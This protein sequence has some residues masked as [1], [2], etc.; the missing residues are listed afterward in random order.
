[1]G[2]GYIQLLAIGSESYFLNYNPNISFFKIYFRRHTNFYINNMEIT[3]NNIKTLNLIDTANKNTITINIPKNG[4]L[5]AKS[6]LNLTIDEY[7]FELFK[8]NEVLCSTLNIDLLNVYDNYYIKTNNYTIKDIANILII[9][10]NFFSTNN[11]ILSVVSS[12]VF[13][14]S[15]ILNYINTQETITL[16]TDAL[17]IFYNIDLNLLFYSFNDV[18]QSNILSNELFNYLIQSIL[19]NKLLYLQIDFL[20]NNI[21][22]KITYHNYQYYK[23]VIDLLI[24]KKF[25]D[26]INKIK[27]DIRYV[28]FSVSF[29]FELYNLL[30]ELFYINSEIFE[31]EIINNKYKS[32]KNVLNEK[33]YNKITSM[34]L[35]KNTDTYI[36]LSILNGDITSYSIITIMEKITFFGNLT[37][38]YYNDLLIQNSNSLLNIFNVNNNKLSLNLLIKIFVS[39]MCYDNNISI[40]NYLKII[41]ENNKITNLDIIKNI[42][43]YELSDKIITYFMDPNILIVNLKTF[44]VIL[45]T[46]NIYQNLQTNFYTR[47]FTNNHKSYYTT[48][49]NTFYS[50]YNLI[51]TTNTIINNNINDYDYMVSQL[52]FFNKFK[53]LSE[54]VALELN[55]LVKNYISNNNLFDINNQINNT[56]TMSTNNTENISINTIIQN[57]NIINDGIYNN[58]LFTLICQS[59]L[60][61]NNIMSF[62]YNYLYSS[63]G[64]LSNVFINSK[65]SQYIFP[66][67]SSIYISTN[68]EGEKCNNNYISNVLIY[69]LNKINYI[70][71]IQNSLYLLSEQYFDNYKISIDNNL[72]KYNMNKYLINSK[73]Y[74]LTSK[75]Y[76]DNDNYI[77]KI[78]MKYINTFLEQIKNIN[79]N[80][81]YP[82]DKKFNLNDKIMFDLFS[83]VDKNLFNDSFQNFTFYKENKCNTPLFETNIRNELI[84]QNFIFTINSPLYRIYFYFTFISKITID[85]YMNID[86]NLVILRNLTFCFLT[87]FLRI[88]NG[89]ILDENL[90]NI[91]DKFNLTKTN[92]IMYFIENNFMCYDN[93]NIFNNN[94]FNDLI[95]NKTSNKY[96]YLYNNFY[97]IKKKISNYN[98]NNI[99]FINNIP[100]FCNELKYN[101]DDLIMK[102]FFDTL[103]DNKN[104]FT[105]FNDIYILTQHFFNK[106]N[107]N[108]NVLMTI[109]NNFN[110]MMSYDYSQSNYDNYTTNNFLYNCYYTSYYIGI[111]FDN[112]NKNNIEIINNVVGLTTLYNDKY[113]FN[114]EYSLKEFNSKQNI[115]YIDYTNNINYPLKYFRIKLYDIFTEKFY[116]NNNYFKNYIEILSSYTN[117]NNDY[118]FLYLIDEYD[119]YNSISIIK[120]YLNVFNDVN[121]SSIT[122]NDNE[123]NIE[124]FT[125]YNFIVIIYYY[126]YFIYKCLSRD[127]NEFNTYNIN[128]IMSFQEF[129]INKYTVNIYDE[130]I[131][132][133]IIIYTKEKQNITFDFS[134]YYIYSIDN[135]VHDNIIFQSM[136]NYNIMKKNIF[137]NITDNNQEINDS[138]YNLNYSPINYYSSYFINNNNEKY[139]Y[140]NKNFNALYCKSI[141]TIIAK[142]NTIFYINDTNNEALLQNYNVSLTSVFNYYEQKKNYYDNSIYTL[143]NIYINL[144]K[145]TNSKIIN[146]QNDTYVS[147]IITC[148][149]YN[150]K[151][152]YFEKENNY[153]YTMYYL[154]YNKNINVINN[155][156]IS[157]D[158]DTTDLINSIDIYSLFSKYINLLISYSIIYE[159]SINRIIYILSTNYLIDNSYNKN[160]TINELKNKTLYDITKL[161]IDDGNNLKKEKIYLNNT[162][163]Y[164]NQSIF[165]IY[166]YENW[167]NNISF[168]QN[169]WVNYIISNI[170]VDYESSNSYHNLFSQ[171]IE[172]VKFFELNLFDFVLDDGIPVLEYFNDI[173]NYDELTNYIFNYLCLNE[174]YSPNLIFNNIIDL[175][176]TNDISSK[177]FIDTEHLKKKI[178]VFLFFTWII[179][180][181][182]QYLLVD[183]KEINRNIVIE[184]NLINNI[185]IKLSNVIDNGN[186]NEII[187]WSIYQ[188]FNMD[189]NMENKKFEITDYPEFIQKNLEILYI[190]K[191]TKFLC[192]PIK[193]FNTLA[194]K[195]VNMYK[196]IIGN[197]NIYTNNL[198]SNKIYNPTITNLI[199]DINVIF[200]NDINNNNKQQYD[201]T[202]YSL[203]LIDIKFKS[204]IYDLTNTT[205]NSSIN[206]SEFINKAKNNYNKTVINDFNLSY[207]LSC[208]L[209]NNY[210][211][212]Y[213]DLSKD[214]NFVINN[215]RRG[216]NNINELFEMF[217]GYITNYTLSLDLTSEK[218]PNTVYNFGIKLFNI[219]KL[220]E[221]VSNNN[222]NLS[223]IAPNDYDVL[224]VMINYK[225]AYNNFYTKYYSYEYNYNNF[226]NNYVVIYKKLYEYYLNL[227]NNTQSIKNIKKYN[228]NLYIWL[229]IDLINATISNTFYNITIQNPNNYIDVINQLIKLYF[230]YNYSFRLNTNIPNTLNLKIQKK[231]YDVPSLN[232]YKSIIE[233]I[234]SYYYYQLF[235]VEISKNDITSYNY[236]IIVFFD[237]LNIEQNLN[238]IYVKNYLNCIFKFIT[239][240]KFIH[241][242]LFSIYN[243]K[244]SVSNDTLNKIIISLIGY[245]IE[246]ENI[247]NYFNIQSINNNLEAQSTEQVYNIINNLVNKKIFYEKFAQSLN[248]LIFWINNKS[249][250]QNI[251][252]V[253]TEYFSNVD[254]E[255]YNVINNQYTIN[256]YQLNITIFNF[257]IQDYIYF[258]FNANFS[259]FIQNTYIKTY[260][261]A[262]QKA[263]NSDEIINPEI[264]NEIILF[265]YDSKK[266][267]NNN[268]KQNLFINKK[269]NKLNSF[270]SI[271]NIFKII[272]N[273]YWGIINYN[274]IENVSNT[275]LRGYIT[276]YNLYYS[277]MNWSLYNEK[278]INNTSEYD[279]NYNS[280]I[281]DELYI[282]Y[283]IIINVYIIQ[284]INIDAYLNLEQE[285][286]TNSHK[287]INYGIKINTQ[288]V[289]SNFSVYMDSL[290]SN[291]IPD[292]KINNYYKIIQ[293]NTIYDSIKYKLHSYDN[294]KNNYDGYIIQIFNNQLDKLNI[295][296][297]NTLGSNTFYNI[298]IN[299]LN[300]LSSFVDMY[301][302]NTNKIVNKIIDTIYNNIK[303]QFS[304]LSDFLG[305][306]KNYNISVNNYG[307]KK[308]FNP[309]NYK[310]E[311]SQITIFS[312]INNEITSSIIN[313]IPIILFYYICFIT[314]TTL[315]INVQND[316]LSIQELFYNMANIINEK[317]LLFI[318]PLTKNESI[319]IFFE[320]LDI[321]LFNNY[322]NNEFIQAIQ[323]FYDKI[324]NNNYPFIKENIVNKLLGINNSLYGSIDY[325]LNRISQL[326]INT[327]DDIIINLE[328]NKIINWKYLLGLLADFNDSKLT[329][330]IKSIDNIFDN[331]KIQ[332]ILIDYI[333][334][335]NGGLTNEYGIIKLIDK[336]EL[337]FDDELISQ[338]F[339]YNYKIFIDNFQNLNKQG[340]LNGML[341][342]NN[343]DD[344]IVS[345][346]KPYIKLSHKKNY[347][348]PIKFFFENYFNSIPLIS[349]M[350]TN[351][352]ILT[353]LENANIFKNSYYI[354]LLTPLNIKSKLNS[355]YILLERDER[356]KLC[357]NKI[358]NLIEKN[359]SYE[360]IKNISQIN[361]S[362]KN[363]IDVDFDLE[364]N[365][366]VKEL[367]W[368]FE[369]SIDN[370]KL[371]D[372][373]SKIEKKIFFNNMQN[374]T[375][376]KLIN[377]DNDFIINTKFY[378]NGMRRDGIQILDSDNLQN[379][380]KI[381]TILNPYKYNTKVKLEKK[382]NVYSFALEPTK[383][384]PS[385]TINMNNYK[386]FKIQLQID[387]NKV[388]KYVNSLNT[389]FGLKDVN[390][391]MNLTT[392]EYNI[393]RYQSSLGGLLFVA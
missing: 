324:I 158:D 314:W 110:I 90:D 322:N 43:I 373:K 164:S 204:L 161:Y 371:S 33:N 153:F 252:D 298:I 83:Y 126:I 302:L 74:I 348:I 89:T 63:V 36:Y 56:V 142:S 18:L 264:I 14:T 268:N 67:S 191:Q 86:N 288:N 284:Y 159:Q 312:L 289:N 215:L 55:I 167:F 220:N 212:N 54:T 277:Y 15:V 242:K 152:F 120:K 39:L 156:N 332:Q 25:I 134:S 9:K 65:I 272:L 184:Y 293:N 202:F 258:I 296:D 286:L 160:E 196:D 233:Y 27:I 247:N 229:F 299:T 194:N 12:N 144:F 186:N 225:Y 46:K 342:I 180:K 267:L 227:T 369:L 353:Y 261:L 269:D 224:P 245:I 136:T 366:S 8:F 389:L 357:S 390:L 327:T 57:V 291:I 178:I 122:L 170:D 11:L 58:F 310:Q 154:S 290:N 203:K 375:M 47:P 112:I 274:I 306:N 392:Y 151:N 370:Y 188:I 358:D 295:D 280:T 100:E 363:I 259:N 32:T 379:Y 132:N 174:F 351:I 113:L 355:D 335:L 41:N 29:S 102:L 231:Y 254:F 105:N 69:N 7:Y 377:T 80:I 232:N 321:L 3:G 145:S 352:K 192:S 275:K 213:S 304:S 2:S 334:K 124:Y 88:F 16:Q 338:Y 217:K 294:N 10:V 244:L 82:F 139:I 303:L 381:T 59:I 195:Y 175:L 171:F 265:E 103:I 211:I 378:L 78:N 216:T 297:E 177:L 230:T 235:N 165:Q 374:I 388:L 128:K 49:I 140:I 162:S 250:E 372:L 48:I 205:K 31:L 148:I 386:T 391:K 333:I 155:L 341:G 5:L 101:Y 53:Y 285:V 340:L 146:I 189:L 201:L 107:F 219:Q 181:M 307:L 104:N 281:F 238:F 77:K 221:L 380:N 109:L 185:D 76:D 24:S 75:Y 22:I 119:F 73:F 23:M 311:N 125:K 385:G 206:T 94:Q 118:L 271:K 62:N 20:E 257:L 93:L 121:N 323:K 147:R 382:Y 45:Y 305:G 279:F 179:L 42:S 135:R 329:Y 13:N 320:E 141:S 72:I 343:S 106:T 239:I 198:T 200:N 30:L 316:L 251:T 172:Y 317:I 208:L 347:S 325:S 246:Y 87:N 95:K 96:S 19:Y 6:Y 64:D 199:S 166:N 70:Q 137:N 326:N 115:N 71:N 116:I 176:Q 345:G 34:I 243:I 91:I 117:I 308:L 38:E 37:N 44:F 313:N 354:N 66:L 367:I 315:G 346:L 337:L 260:E 209:L 236:D 182:T 193:N 283:W 241:Y 157:S 368:S 173:N 50:I 228:L 79:Y 97:V 263:I 292:N 163:I 85:D 301:L 218:N 362:N 138:K 197:S 249:Y 123:L 150:L 384:Q 349:C 276:F 28:Y 319:Y 360:I 287:Y 273:N 52:L 190:V 81:I 364:L 149:L 130:C 40:Q 183:F 359:N 60:L 131:E 237:T 365:N 387:K 51:N 336:I 262:F 1:M 344:N 300:N 339:K 331:L 270:K 98:I 99:E 282:L 111:T 253:W 318:N 108:F 234:I 383:F 133:L 26:F 143:E 278:S 248:K 240:I 309:C 361:D 68:E 187:N 35:N 222:N 84:Y 207:Y 17:N 328:N 168:T 356:K 376:D 129:I 214:F 169:Y 226:N 21:S 114:Y 61:L 223:L 350:N 127:I 4:D 255:Y 330:Y 266:F 92:N 210:L 256:Q 393:V